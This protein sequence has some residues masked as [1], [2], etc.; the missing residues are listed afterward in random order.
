[1]RT[2]TFLALFSL[3]TLATG[4]FQADEV[5]IKDDT[6]A[7]AGDTDETGDTLPTGD[8]VVAGSASR[9]IDTC[10]PTGDFTGTLCLF[11]LSTCDDLTSAVATAEIADAY[12]YMPSDSVDWE[13]AQVPDG[14]W[15]LWGFLDDDASGCDA[16]TTND[17]ASECQA[18]EVLDGQ[19]VS[20]LT[21]ELVSKCSA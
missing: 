9:T 6:D 11:L 12:L 20:G 3:T 2:T 7:T 14:S 21:V 8:A 10:P 1:M 18:V 19:D 5:E 15:Q 4:C 16:P 17:L 13:I